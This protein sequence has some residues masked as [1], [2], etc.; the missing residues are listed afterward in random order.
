MRDRRER[1]DTPPWSRDP[2]FQQG[3]FLNVFREQDKGSQ[4][5]IRFCQPVA[6][7]FPELLHALFFGRWCNQHSTLD[8]LSPAALHK[9]EQLRHALLSRVPQPWSSE[10][11]PVVP[12]LWNGETF[13]RL[14]A[15]VR[16]L[17]SCIGFLE[18]CI[19]NA[20]GD[21][22]HATN[23]INAQF[24]MSNDFP[25]FM[26]VIDVSWFEPTIISP[27]SRVPTGIGAEP[28][29]DRLQEHLAVPDHHSACDR[30]IELQA[31]CWPEAR[32]RFTPVDIEYLSCECRKYYSYIHG[33][34][35]FEGKNLF[36][37]R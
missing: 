25:I 32:R 8:R 12:A 20:N 2:V 23:A 1:G 22:V 17:P 29:L 10:A 30:M 11:Y 24:Q 15:C 7:S 26:A 18:T 35:T 6:H 9:P 14:E 28:F 21:V 5:L 36:T 27:D 19:R 4:A 37:P 16:M 3:R 34:K 13:D 33:T 31:E